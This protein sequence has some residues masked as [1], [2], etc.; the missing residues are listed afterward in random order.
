MDAIIAELRLILLVTKLC[1]LWPHPSSLECTGRSSPTSSGSLYLNWAIE[2]CCLKGGIFEFLLPTSIT[3]EF[4]QLLLIWVAAVLPVNTAVGV[5]SY[6]KEWHLK[7]FLRPLGIKFLGFWGREGK[8]GKAISWDSGLVR[9]PT[10]TS[11]WIHLRP[12]LDFG[13]SPRSSWWVGGRV[14]SSTFPNFMALCS[15]LAST[16]FPGLRQVFSL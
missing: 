15:L 7:P 9:H 8:V 3:T 16:L 5:T 14:E 11:S 6:F 4:Q 13:V 10:K 12:V 2:P 1:P